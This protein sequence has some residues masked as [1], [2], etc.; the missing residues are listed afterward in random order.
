VIYVFYPYGHGSGRAAQFRVADDEL[1]RQEGRAG[2][3]RRRKNRLQAAGV[4]KADRGTTALG[5][6]IAKGVAV[7]IKAGRAVEL[8]EGAFADDLGSTG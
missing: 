2:H 8:D 5:P 1:E 3:R 7:R 4:R 6:G